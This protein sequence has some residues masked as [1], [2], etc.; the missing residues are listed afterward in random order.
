MISAIILAAGQSQRMGQ[1]KFLLPWGKKKMIKQTLEIYLESPLAEIILVLGHEA[2]RILE[3]ISPLP[4][5]IMINSAYPEGMSSSLRC[6]LLAVNQET[7]GILIALG[8]Q[9]G[10]RREVVAD[11]VGAFQK[12]YPRQNIFV[13]TY[14]GQRGH[15]VI[16]SKKFF[17]EI[18]QL[19]GDVGGREILSRNETEILEVQ[20]ESEGILWD[21]DT[22]EDY[23][24]YLPKREN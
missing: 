4:V 6:G 9:P 20:V 13:P 8:D 23:F 15:P 10:I 5:K 3:E 18:E 24:R 14:A 22:M 2:E 1:N 16:F 12:F 17:G 21:I 19:R 11:L 7:T